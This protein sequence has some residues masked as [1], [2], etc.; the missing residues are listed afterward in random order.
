MSYMKRIASKDK[1]KVTEQSLVK[2]TCPDIFF[3]AVK[4]LLLMGGFKIVAFLV[5]KV[6]GED[7]GRGSLP[8]LLSPPAND[9][10]IYTISR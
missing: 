7:T 5:F 1:I 10:Y 4:W 9:K 3:P 6:V 8:W 2:E